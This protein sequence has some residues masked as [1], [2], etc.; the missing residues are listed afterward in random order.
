MFSSVKLVDDTGDAAL[1][2]VVPVDRV[3]EIDEAGRCSLADQS[4]I[5]TPAMLEK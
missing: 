5:I 1:E 2:A 4:F 3:V